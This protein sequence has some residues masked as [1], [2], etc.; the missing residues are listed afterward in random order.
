[1]HSTAFRDLR[2][3]SD[4]GYVPR[5][6]EEVQLF[7]VMAGRL[8]DAARHPG[9]AD[10]QREWLDG[11][12]G[13]DANSPPLHGHKTSYWEARRALIEKRGPGG[14]SSVVGMCP[15]D[16]TDKILTSDKDI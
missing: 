11:T 6:Q 2:S 13:V 16:E 7:N 14:R 15:R 4:R 5:W 8:V 1:L 12:V 10:I 3:R 9:H